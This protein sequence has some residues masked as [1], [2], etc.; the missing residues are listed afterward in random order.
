M[1]FGRVGLAYFDDAEAVAE[2]I[3]R[4]NEALGGLSRVNFQMTIAA[5]PHR[6]ML[7]AIEIL[8]TRVAPLVR[9]SLAAAA[10]RPTFNGRVA[11]AE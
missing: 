2:K 6:Q 7:R 10:R 9:Q 1:L 4:V 5:V 11:A 3:L 8:G